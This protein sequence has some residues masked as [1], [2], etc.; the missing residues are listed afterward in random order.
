MLAE[1]GM[2]KRIGMESILKSYGRNNVRGYDGKNDIW[3]L[4]DPVAPWHSIFEWASVGN[5]L[6]KGIRD[7]G[8]VQPEWRY[9]QSRRGIGN[10]RQGHIVRVSAGWGSCV[11]FRCRVCRRMRT[12]WVHQ[13]RSYMYPNSVECRCPDPE[14]ST[15]SVEW[16]VHT[17]TG[18]I[19]NT[20]RQVISTLPQD[21]YQCC[22]RLEGWRSLLDHSFRHR[23]YTVS[24]RRP[25]G[26]AS[27]DNRCWQSDGWSGGASFGSASSVRD[28][29]LPE[30]T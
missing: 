11:R 16:R 22:I 21:T 19:T 27:M 26:I 18:T 3:A 6:Q 4:H 5:T 20:L 17:C 25:T 29:V 24:R 7:T 8:S 23:T 10:L 2:S 30:S 13:E 14:C 28:T 15:S 12:S 9:W 1:V